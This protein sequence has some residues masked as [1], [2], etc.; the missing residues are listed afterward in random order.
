[1]QTNKILL[2]IGAV[3]LL[4][5]ILFGVYK[6]VNG[7][8][9]SLYPEI[10]VV[11]TTDHIKWSPEKK[12]VLVVYSDFQCP[13]CKNFHNLLN[14]FEASG[15]SDLDITKKVTL[16]YRHFPLY[17]LHQFSLDAS[18][19][20]EATGKQG[21]FNEM[22]DLLFNSQEEW[23]KSSNPKEYFVKLAQNLNLNIDQF[24]KDID[25]SSV[26]DRVQEDITSGEKA[27]IN[28]TPT[29]F[30][31]GRKLENIQSIDDFKKQLRNP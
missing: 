25:S 1:M 3:I 23:D 15:S 19:T 5:V 7:S 26:K 2:A 29:F 10:N 8:S 17:Q 28:S 31:N 24:K 6:L 16:V 4:F 14:G 27:V 20:A 9:T 30:L 12:N 18:Y 21:K 11:K 22:S 13:A